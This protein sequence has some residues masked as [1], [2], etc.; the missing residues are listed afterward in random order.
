M[1]VGDALVS[2]MASAF[3]VGTYTG[4][5]VRIKHPIGEI[6]FCV[7]YTFYN[8]VYVAQVSGGPDL[9]DSKSLQFP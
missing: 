2:V 8:H 9:S 5:Q 4:S 6:F 3:I 7:R 1:I